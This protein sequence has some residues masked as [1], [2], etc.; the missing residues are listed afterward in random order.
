M[1]AQDRIWV[2]DLPEGLQVEGELQALGFA[3]NKPHGLY[4][5]EMLFATPARRHA[6][7]LAKALREMVGRHQVYCGGPVLPFAG[8]TDKQ[9]MEKAEAALA[10]LEA[11]T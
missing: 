4:P 6:D 10:K 1:S 2:S 7:E 5:I 8:Y 3:W 11:D 9:I